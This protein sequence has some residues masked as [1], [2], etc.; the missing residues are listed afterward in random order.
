MT[1][2]GNAHHIH[3]PLKDTTLVHKIMH[4]LHM[5]LYDGVGVYWRDAH[6]RY[7]DI[8]LRFRDA[9]N[10]YIHNHSNSPFFFFFS[11]QPLAAVNLGASSKH[12]T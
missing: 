4:V 3:Y 9:W 2:W 12:S 7:A 6:K 10:T 8:R 1:V 11:S 5:P